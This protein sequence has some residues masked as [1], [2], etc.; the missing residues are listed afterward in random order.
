MTIGAAA[1]SHF[2]TIG[3]AD[4]VNGAVKFALLDQDGVTLVASYQLVASGALR[5]PSILWLRSGRWLITYITSGDTRNYR[6]STN[7][8]PRLATDWVTP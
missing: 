1:L 8:Y 5:N 3:V 4:N 7:A 2:D 6:R